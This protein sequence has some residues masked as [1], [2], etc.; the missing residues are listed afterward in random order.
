MNFRSSFFLLLT[1]KEGIAKQAYNISL[2]SNTHDIEF[3][4]DNSNIKADNVVQVDSYKE[5][6]EIVNSIIDVNVNGIN[7]KVRDYSLP[8]S[9]TAILIPPK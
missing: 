2:I 1:I 3:I 7:D 4:L 5:A 9:L 6:E 8:L